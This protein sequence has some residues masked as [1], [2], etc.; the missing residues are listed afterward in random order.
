MLYVNRTIGGPPGG[1]NPFAPAVAL[2]ANTADDTDVAN[3]IAAGDLDGDGDP[4]FVFGTWSRMNGAVAEK[5]PDRYYVNNSTPAGART[6]RPP[7]PSGRQSTRPTS[8]SATSTTTPIS[9]RSW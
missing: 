3:S 9:T 4:D 1:A 7:V 8:G 5:A 2:D 6:S